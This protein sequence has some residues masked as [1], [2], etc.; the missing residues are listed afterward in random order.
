MER[1]PKRWSWLGGVGRAGLVPEH[2]VEARLADE[3]GRRHAVHVAGR[4]GDGGIEVRV[5]VES[6]HE[7]GTPDLARVASD[8]V[9]RAHAEAVVA[10]EHERE[11]SVPRDGV[12]ALGDEPGPS[13]NLRQVAGLLRK[14][15]PKGSAAGAGVG[16][17]PRSSTT[18]S[19]S[20]RLSTRPAR[21][22]AVGPITA[23]GRLAPASIGTPITTTRGCPLTIA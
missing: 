19:S 15:L 21:R 6:E 10:A 18:T 9:D 4:R 23:P 1:M 2:R 11:G 16:R 8:A 14:L 12:G 17:S 22:S 13:R 3:Q 7:K 20:R 5:R